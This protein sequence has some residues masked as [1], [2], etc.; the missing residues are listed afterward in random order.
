[1]SDG[2]LIKQ[3]KY[4]ESG[5]HIGTRMRTI[6]MQKFIFKRRSDDLYVL[7]LRVIDERIRIAAKI[8]SKY[9]PKKVYVVASR[10]YSSVAA[11]VFERLTSIKV[12]SGRFIPG[13]FTNVGRADFVEPDLVI[14]CDPKGEKQ[15]VLECGEMGIP[16]IGLCDTDNYTMFIDWIIPCNNK[17]RKSLS[18]IFWLLARELA[19]SSNKI[20]TYDEFRPTLEEFENSCSELL[21]EESLKSNKEKD[22][23]IKQQEDQTSQNSQT[24]KQELEN[25]TASNNEN[26]EPQTQISQNSNAE[27]AIREENKEEIKKEQKEK[28]RKTKSSKKSK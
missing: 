12:I 2:L 15:A 3:E 21:E 28:K 13:M 10:T 18:L 11:K 1:M 25:N 19:M 16:T 14:I 5:I 9:D 26:K 27:P 23:E 7:D 24:E 17:G 20:S 6:D 4:L 8:I 22:Q